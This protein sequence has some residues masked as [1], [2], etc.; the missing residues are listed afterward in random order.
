MRPL[1]ADEQR[2]IDLVREAARQ[3]RALPGVTPADVMAVEAWMVAAEHKV[4]ALAVDAARVGPS[5]FK[6]RGHGA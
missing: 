6:G 5:E 2:V 4:R 1:T 3:F